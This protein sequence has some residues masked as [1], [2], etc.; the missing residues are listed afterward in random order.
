MNCRSAVPAREP[1]GNAVRIFAIQ[2]RGCPRNCKRQVR[3]KCHWSTT[4]REGGY[5]HRAASQETCRRRGPLSKPSG[6]GRKEQDNDH[7]FN[8]ARRIGQPAI[9]PACS[10]LSPRCSASSSSASSASRISTSSTTPRT[11]IAIRWRSPATEE[12]LIPCR[13]FATSSSSRRWRGLLA[14]VVMTALQMFATVPLILQAEV[15]ENAGSGR[16]HDHAAAPADPAAG[17]EAAAPAHEHDAEAWEPADGFERYAFTVARQHRH[18]HRLCADPGRRLRIRRRHR[19]LA[20]GPVLG[21]RRL[22]RVHAGA[23]PRPAAGAAGD[24]RRRPL[25]AAGLVDGARSLRPP[26]AWR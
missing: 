11:T 14:G 15:Y 25:A 1:R 20:P 9:A 12:G 26:P 23:R 19:Q 10:L 22:R 6:G 16:E 21:P 8:L 3:P 5:E 18:R 17:T 2:S 13:C 7:R 4:L 24:A